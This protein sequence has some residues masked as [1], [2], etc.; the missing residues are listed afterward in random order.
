MDRTF[1]KSSPGQ[2]SPNR[3][4]GGLRLTLATSGCP[5]ASPQQPP[6]LPTWPPGSS[7]PRPRRPLLAGTTCFRDTFCVPSLTRDSGR[8]LSAPPSPLKPPEDPGEQALRGV[9]FPRT[10]CR[11]AVVITGPQGSDTLPVT[12]GKHTGCTGWSTHV[13]KQLNQVTR[14]AS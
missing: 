4:A 3:P 8:G 12:K 9:W 1:Q 7:S 6:V 13:C 2:P 5:V 11:G 10:Q 14:G